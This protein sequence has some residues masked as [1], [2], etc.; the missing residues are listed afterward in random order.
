M[1]EPVF[2]LSVII[3]I[4]DVAS[5]SDSLLWLL[6]CTTLSARTLIAD[7]QKAPHPVVILRREI[8][9]SIRQY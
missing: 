1:A 9:Q 4:I 3:T 7:K 5:V 2:A 8:L 6:Q